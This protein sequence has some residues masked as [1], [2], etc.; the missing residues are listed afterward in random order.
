MNAIL[1]AAQDDQVSVDDYAEGLVNAAEQL[2]YIFASAKEQSVYPDDTR[3]S[4]AVV[5][6]KDGIRQKLSRKVHAQNRP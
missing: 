6:R 3:G 5:S 4:E 1:L 2:K